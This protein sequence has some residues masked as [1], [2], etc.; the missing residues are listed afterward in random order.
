MKISVLIPAYKAASTIEATLDAVLAQTLPPDE[1]VV[2]LDGVVDDTPARLERYR[3]RVREVIQDNQ[4]VACA[5]NRLT[6]LAAGEILAFVDADDLWHPDYLKQQHTVLEKFPQAVASYTGHLRFLGADHVWS[7]EPPPAKEPELLDQTEF[8]TRYN[9]VTAMFGSM[10]YCCVR[11]SAI[12]R[13]GPN[14]FSTDLHAIE[15]SYLAYQ[16]ALLG[17]VAF[18]PMKLVAYRLL[19]GSLSHNRVRNLG[20]WVTA[21]ERL[22]ARYRQHESIALARA[23]SKYYASKRRE[24]AKILLGVG[25]GPEA[26]QQLTRSLGN[27]VRPGSL[28]KST[29]IWLASILPKPLQ[30]AWPSAVREVRPG[31]SGP[32]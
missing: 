29:G 30:P 17:P 32:A 15:D 3:P 1:I 16:L 13:M 31:G 24:Y 20:R 6:E 5:R 23:F 10:S 26:R 22:E 9:V 4:G 19:E 21:F 27:C 14:P 2:L 25:R 12:D 8:F 7:P 11:K 18:L 28:V